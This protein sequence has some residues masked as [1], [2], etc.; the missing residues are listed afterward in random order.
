[1]KRKV[2]IETQNPKIVETDRNVCYRTYE[3]AVIRVRKKQCNV[4][5][6]MNYL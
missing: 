2:K 3:K 4:S 6:R 1:M 5:S